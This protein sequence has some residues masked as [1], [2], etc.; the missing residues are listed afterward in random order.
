MQFLMKRPETFYPKR[1]TFNLYESQPDSGHKDI[2]RVLPAEGALVFQML[3]LSADSGVELVGCELFSSPS[4][5]NSLHAVVF[6]N[7]STVSL[8][9]GE[10]VNGLLCKMLLLSFT[11]TALGELKLFAFVFVE[12]CARWGLLT[13]SNTFNGSHMHSV[14]HTHHITQNCSDLLGFFK[15]KMNVVVCVQR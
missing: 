2:H 3:C 10:A 8:E 12:K 13:S 6:T 7:S 14:V 5:D 11:L 1:T 4:Q 9:E 15:A